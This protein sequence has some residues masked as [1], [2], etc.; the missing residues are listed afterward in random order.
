[1]VIRQ[2]IKI[3]LT[4]I[5]ATLS[6][7]LMVLILFLITRIQDVNSKRDEPLVI[8]L[9]EETYKAFQEAMNDK[10]P[11][12]TEIKPL[13]GEDIK[14]IA[15]N[16]ANQI[17]NKISTEKYIEELK[18]ELNIS[19]LNQQLDRSLGDESFISS[20]VKEE[21]RTETQPKN[22]FYK[23]PTR[24]EYNFSRSHRFI[25]VPV[26][27]CQGSGRIM[28]DIVV[29]ERGEVVAATLNSTNTSEECIIETA[30]QSARISSFS[31]D[32]NANPRE[33]GTISYEFVAQ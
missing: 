26:Y 18:Q 4:G 15:V 21:K 28:V 33:K 12:I 11:E 23:G 29:N 9:D 2:D 30:L 19:E 22:T 10:K 8:E 3:T 7:H 6:V 31:S 24:V 16:T 20:E 5:L 17:E 27:K 32:L 13:S 14:N 25:H 1:M